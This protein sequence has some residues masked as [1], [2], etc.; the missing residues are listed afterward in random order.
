MGHVSLLF[1]VFK[2]KIGDWFVALE[3]VCWRRVECE[4]CRVRQ[5][6]WAINSSNV[7]M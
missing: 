1:G 2:E 7:Y 5:M 3:R 4:S 6:P